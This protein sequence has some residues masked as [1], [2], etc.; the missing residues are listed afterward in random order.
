MTYLEKQKRNGKNY[1]YLAHSIRLKN[2]KY[3]KI[4]IYIKSCLE[5]LT[6]QEETQLILDNFEILEEKINRLYPEIS[7]D[8]NIDIFFRDVD[9][10]FLKSHLI[11]VEIVKKKFA[12][13]KS[14]LDYYNK[15]REK[16]IILHA[17]NST[18]VEGNTFTKKDTELLLTKGFIVETKQLREANE[19]LNISKA[20][21]YIEDYDK[22]LS[23]KFICDLH[24][25]VT[26]N[27]LLEARNEGV[28][29]PSGINVSMGASDYKNVAGGRDVKKSLKVSID[30]FKTLYETDKLGAIVRFYASFIAIHP[31]I[32][33]NGRTSRI[34][35]N[36]LLKKE[37]LP[38]IN[39]EA[40]EHLIHIDGIDKA[41]R[42]NGFNDLAGFILDKILNNMFTK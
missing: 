39:Y 15:L 21:D 10:L 4:R 6:E 34:L 32:D 31:F 20:L 5:D 30:K 42:G 1:Y 18:K 35:L 27:T 40:K 41:I 24:K 13:I 2:N 8:Y 16:Y 29:R 9:T 23:I 3:K 11:D 38:Y 19:I 14:N 36:W 33:G 7:T 37:K 26:H 12:K 17:Y 28:L 25:I 22:D